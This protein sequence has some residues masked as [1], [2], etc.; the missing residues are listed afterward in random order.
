MYFCSIYCLDL[1]GQQVATKT[2]LAAP[3]AALRSIE[4]GKKMTLEAPAL[5][6]LTAPGSAPPL[7]QAPV[8]PVPQAA[9]AA[10]PTPT[11]GVRS[12]GTAPTVFPLDVHHKIISVPAPPKEMKNKVR[13]PVKNVVNGK[14]G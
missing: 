1:H 3:P 12:A 5:A 4:A 11:A 14:L 9:T 7:P 13:K 2:V 10:V 8:P 6:M